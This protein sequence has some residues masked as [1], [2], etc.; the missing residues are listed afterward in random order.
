MHANGARTHLGTIANPRFCTF[1]S[2]RCD[3][4]EHRPFTGARRGIVLRYGLI[5]RDFISRIAIAPSLVLY[6]A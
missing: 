6:C 2:M 1:V 3:V 4:V 5:L